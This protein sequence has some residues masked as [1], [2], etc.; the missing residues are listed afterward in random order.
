MAR[1]ARWVYQLILSALLLNRGPEAWQEGPG[2]Q[3][4]AVVHPDDLHGDPIA[5]VE[6]NRPQ[7]E[8]APPP[9]VPFV[10]SSQYPWNALFAH[11]D[12]YRRHP[13][14][15]MQPPDNTAMIWAAVEQE[16]KKAAA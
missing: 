16:R 15:Y 5:T 4:P 2:V 3:P 12:H 7:V 11:Y 10:P 8:Q 14:Y 1:A 13:S 9:G 6:D